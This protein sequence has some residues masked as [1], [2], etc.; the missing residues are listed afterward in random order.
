MTFGTVAVPPSLLRFP[1]NPVTC[2]LDSHD[3]AAHED[4][5]GVG[6]DSGEPS[7]DVRRARVRE[8]EQDNAGTP[9]ASECGKIAEVQIER[10][11][12]ALFGE[13]CLEDLGIRRAVQRTNLTY[14]EMRTSSL[15]S[16]AAYSSAC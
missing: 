14:D 4:F 5:R 6:E 3:N 11:D 2:V 12:D 9:V 15:I 13:R 8:P 1:Q 16:Q 7:D 10:E